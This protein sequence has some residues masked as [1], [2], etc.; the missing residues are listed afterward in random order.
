MYG[1]LF[2]P[3]ERVGEKYKL[4][5]FID[6]EKLKEE[7]NKNLFSSKNQQLRRLEIDK[8]Y[9]YIERYKKIH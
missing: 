7:Y 8:G 4:G 2:T 1:V 9:I 3:L 5:D 6:V